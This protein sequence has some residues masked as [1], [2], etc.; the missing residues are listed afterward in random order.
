MYFFI[1]VV[2]FQFNVQLFKYCICRPGSIIIEFKLTFKTQVT[3]RDALAPLRKEMATG[4][5]GSL[6][7]DPTSLKELKTVKTGESPYGF[8]KMYTKAMMLSLWFSTASHD[9]EIFQ[10]KIQAKMPDC[11]DKSH[12]CD[13]ENDDGNNGDDNPD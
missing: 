5:L 1:V 3:P 11:G 13:K 9:N 10:Q 8:I 12:A 4:N 6:R 7:V 2:V